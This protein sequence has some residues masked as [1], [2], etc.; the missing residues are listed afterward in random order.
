MR[1]LLISKSVIILARDSYLNAIGVQFAD[2]Y[3][4]GSGKA[5]EASEE[6]IPGLRIALHLK[7][8]SGGAKQHGASDVVA[9]LGASRCGGKQVK[10]ISGYLGI[11]DPIAERLGVLNLDVN[12]VLP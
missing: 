1:K 7:P 10:K 2:G 12:T 5:R 4:E 11:L 3:V 8:C 9:F 6:M